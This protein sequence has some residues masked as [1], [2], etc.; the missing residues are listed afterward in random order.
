MS[1]S[2]EI[3]RCY[4]DIGKYETIRGKLYDIYNNCIPASNNISSISGPLKN[5]YFI[6][7]SE[8]G[9]G[10]KSDGLVRDIN[11]TSSMIINT[12][13][14]EINNEIYRLQQKIYRLKAEDA[15]EEAREAAE[16]NG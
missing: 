5:N 6:N 4:S 11:N 1:H 15:A 14:P 13:I 8:S 3:N 9:I 2:Y 7:G 16:S 12:V 10:S